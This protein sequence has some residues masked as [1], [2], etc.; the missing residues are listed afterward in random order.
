MARTARDIH[1]HLEPVPSSEP[2]RHRVAAAIVS[3][4]RTG[5]LHPGDPLPP[6]RTLAADLGVSRAVV[7][8]AYDELAAAGYVVTR[9]GSGTR[10]AADAD[11]AARA[12]ADPHVPPPPVPEP[13]VPGSE[14][15]PGIDLAPGHPD[16][17]LISTRDWRSAWRFAAGTPAPH[18]PPGA[19]GHVELRRALAVHLRRT[20]GIAAEPDDIVIVPGVSAA[21]RTLVAA[22][23]LSGR[24]IAFEDPGY[25]MVR[26]ILETG[27]ARIRPVPVD[28]D[29]IDPALVR[30]SDAAVY[31][32]PAHQYPMGARMPVAR[33]AALV[34]A[35]RAAGQLVIEDD[36][37]GEFRYGVAPLP[38]L[39]SIDGGRDCV[40]YVG[41]TSKILSPGLRLAWIVPPAHLL[42]PIHRTLRLSG[43]SACAV[44]ALALARFIE[45]GAL[46][47]HLARAARTYAARRHALVDALRTR[48]PGMDPTG[49]EAGLH[50]AVRLPDGVDDDAVADEIARHG[51]TVRSLADYRVCDSG[52]RGLLC[53]YARLPESRAD[54]AATVI[55]NVI[56]EQGGTAA[57]TSGR[58]T[59]SGS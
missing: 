31:C 41:T 59:T 22:A 51:V 14:R 15:T 45:S 54:V 37:D 1:L 24:E 49:V 40:A 8:D 42:E 44:T 30:T 2:L 48:L 19:D 36:Y 52:P 27:G 13:P 47:R 4:V 34:A 53:G 38:A 43:D 17:D 57:G 39:R 50:V 32:T 26:R 33:R 5:T 7:V 10:I 18:A 9:P 35:A 23:G 46:T 58:G 12:G 11:R 21:M 6:S 56:R 3:A 55:A 29:G 20:R 16:T 28:H 25:A